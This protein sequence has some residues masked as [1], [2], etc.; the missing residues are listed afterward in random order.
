MQESEIEPAVFATA[1]ILLAAFVMNSA[2]VAF[3]LASLFAGIW[4]RSGSLDLVILSVG[5][6]PC[7]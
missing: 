2:V 6:H 3:L 4:Y 1:E 5:S 7:G